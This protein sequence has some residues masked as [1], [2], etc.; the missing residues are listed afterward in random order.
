MRA[1]L[2]LPQGGLW[3]LAA[4]AAAAGFVSG[5]AAVER[6]GA[7]QLMLS[8]P[9]VLAPL[10]GLALGDLT[11][12]L[13]LGV[14]LELLF[15]GGVNLGGAVP[16]NETLLTVALASSVL[17]AGLASGMGADPALCAL[18]LLL[19]APLAILGR[20]LDRTGEARATALVGRA[21]VLATLGDPDPARVQLRGLA[22]PFLTTAAICICA[23]LASPL[24][25]ALRLRCGGRML[26]GL[27]GSWHAALA[28]SVA[29]AIRAIREPRAVWLAGLSALAVFGAALL[30]RVHV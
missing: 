21:R 27:E 17:P 7:F 4:L 19:L 20:W 18:G 14:P 3:H 30:M 28:L 29:A 13:L 26:V 11:G 10:L 2:P 22:W 12:G 5:L 25:A 24:L 6:K 15:V 16:E 8:R 23:V 1:V 9:L